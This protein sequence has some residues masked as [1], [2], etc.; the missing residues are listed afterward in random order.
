MLS[1]SIWVQ[2]QVFMPIRSRDMS[3]TVKN[4]ISR[5]RGRIMT[6]YSRKY[7]R[8]SYPCQAIQFESNIKSLCLFV[9][10]IC[11]KRWKVTISRMRGRIMTELVRKY[12]KAHTLVNRFNLNPTSSLYAFPFSRYRMNNEKSS[13][14]HARRNVDLTTSKM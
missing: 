2:Y 1:D 5:M 9:L 7:K 13:F 4:A 8:N 11:Q 10:E 14:A 6:E 12:W 3:K